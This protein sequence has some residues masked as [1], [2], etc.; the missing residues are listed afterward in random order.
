MR[1]TTALFAVYG[2]PFSLTGVPAIPEFIGRE[3]G[4]ASLWAILN[5]LNLSSR[6]I[7]VLHGTGG[8]GK[9]QL[10]VALARKHKNDFTAIFWLDAR[11]KSS[12]IRSLAK[13]SERL[14]PS[15]LQHAG[16]ESP[17]G[18]EERSRGITRWLGLP[19]N[20]SWLL[21]FDDAD[22][23]SLDQ[24]SDFFPAGD[25]GRIVVTTRRKTFC[26]LGLSF[27]VQKIP[28]QEAK[29]VFKSSA[30]LAGDLSTDCQNDIENLCRYLDG[31]PLALSS[32]GDF[33][34]ST[35][36]TAAEYLQFYKTQWV[37]LQSASSPSRWYSRGTLNQTWSD[38]YSALKSDS[39]QAALLLDS[40][41]CL[42]DDKIS[43]TT[44]HKT[45]KEHQ[46]RHLNEDTFNK[47]MG[48][49][50]DYSFAELM[51]DGSYS[52]NS[53]IRSWFRSRSAS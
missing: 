40:I 43:F 51:D 25:G 7:M 52:I 14:S 5:P 4:L 6:I 18:E 33:V 20:S 31:L 36:S 50:V 2:V 37:E 41:C 3:E 24:I 39:R 9:T 46:K 29:E 28:L 34:R 38:T 23:L 17:N 16:I 19:G 48:S 47:H 8:V 11:N 21:V 15:Q 35:S 26:Q 32:A 44:F 45:L 12:L 1:P 27:P 22:G 49:I 42:D 30:H 10:A 53:V 13:A